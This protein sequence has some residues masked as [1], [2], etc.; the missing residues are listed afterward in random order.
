VVQ[1][2]YTDALGTHG[3]AVADAVLMVCRGPHPTDPP[4]PAPPPTPPRPR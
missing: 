1:Q 2:R 4:P 3:P